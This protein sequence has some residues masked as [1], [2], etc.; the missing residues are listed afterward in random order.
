MIQS[1][2]MIFYQSTDLDRTSQLIKFLKND[3]MILSQYNPGYY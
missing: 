1:E 2:K 3:Y